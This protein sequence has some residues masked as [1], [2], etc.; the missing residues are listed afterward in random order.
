MQFLVVDPKN[1]EEIRA[2]FINNFVD[3]TTDHYKKY[4][5]TLK[6]Y[7]DGMCYDGYLWDSLKADYEIIEKTM[8][9]AIDYLIAKGDVFVMWDN[10]SNHRVFD[11][12]ILS[13]NYPKKTIIQMN[14][15]ELCKYIKNEWGDYFNKKYL[16]DDIYIFDNSFNWYVIFTHEGHEKY[17]KPELTEDDYIRI[18]FV[19]EM[20]SVDG[21][22][23]FA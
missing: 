7:P 2:N 18:C 22:D 14:S 15:A 17:D 6:K 3:T 19:N 23:M 9:Q 12:A 10:Y 20:N 8:E 13:Y 16:P 4:I 11:N 1:Q 21:F 5:A